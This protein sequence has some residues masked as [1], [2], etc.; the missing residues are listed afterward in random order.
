MSYGKAE[1]PCA[2]YRAWKGQ[3]PMCGNC[4]WLE[5]DHKV[6]VV[7]DKRVWMSRSINPKAWF[8][9][10]QNHE[11]FSGQKSEAKAIIIDDPQKPDHKPVRVT[12]RFNPSE[13]ANNRA[14]ARLVRQMERNA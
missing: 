1:K 4:A 3:E 13:C 2:E 14:K 10:K 8:S 6:E 12:N 5:T 11:D 9:K 7:H